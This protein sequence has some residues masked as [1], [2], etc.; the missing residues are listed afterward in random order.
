MCNVP[1]LFQ[2]LM[3]AIFNEYLFSF[4]LKLLNKFL[5]FSKSEEENEEHLP[6]VFEALRKANLKIKPKKCKLYQ[7][8]VTYLG[9]KLSAEKIS[10][11][12]GEIRALK[13][14]KRPAN[15]TELSSFNGFCSYSRRFVKDFA[16]IA[17]PLHEIT[18]KNRRFTWIPD[19]QAAFEN[20]KTAMIESTVLSHPDY[21]SP[22][23][24][25][26]DASYKSLGAVLSNI[27]DGVKYPVAFASRVL[28]PAKCKYIATKRRH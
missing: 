14:W 18:K 8:S 19:C 27:I 11:D 9:Y 13:E 2:R 15:F 17:K 6:I 4:V 10:P 5:V 26:T 24:L 16:G 23:V 25:D 7:N 22:F 12:E 1:G 28:S 21:S 20:L 3:T